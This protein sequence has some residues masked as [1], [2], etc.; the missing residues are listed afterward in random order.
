[1]IA[2]GEKREEYREIK[3]YWTKRLC[4][5][6]EYDAVQFRNGYRP[7]SPTALVELTGIASGQGQ[8]RWGAGRDRVYILR[9]GR[10]LSVH[11]NEGERR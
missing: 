3:P 4:A 9:L 8:T 1:M 11:N 5:P 2:S 10:V 7:D 6:G